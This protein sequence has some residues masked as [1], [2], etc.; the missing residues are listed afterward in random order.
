[1]SGVIGCRPNELEADAKRKMGYQIHATF[2]EQSLGPR[3]GGR[4]NIKS[5]SLELAATAPR[6]KGHQIQVPPRKQTP[7]EKTLHTN[8]PSNQ[9]LQ[10]VLNL[11]AEFPASKLSETKLDMQ[12]PPVNKSDDW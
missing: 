11:N 7:R 12:G 5:G 4:R 1:M 10:R 2:S 8:C 3:L 9:T 6:E